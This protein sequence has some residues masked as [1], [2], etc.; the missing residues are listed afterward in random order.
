MKTEYFSSFAL[1]INFILLTTHMSE[2][3]NGKAELIH[4]KLNN[5]KGKL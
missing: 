3:L 5:K 2:L 1:L 4:L